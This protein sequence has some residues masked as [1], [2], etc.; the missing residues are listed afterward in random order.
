MDEIVKH[1]R[2]SKTPH[3]HKLRVDVHD[4]EAIIWYLFWGESDGVDDHHHMGIA[5]V[6]S[7]GSGFEIAWLHG[8]DQEPY[9]TERVIDSKELYAKI[10]AEIASR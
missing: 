3:G 2:D 5:R 4:H 1:Y 9:R 7:S 10:D 6:R 8:T